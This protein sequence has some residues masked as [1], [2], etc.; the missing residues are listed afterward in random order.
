M[1][2]NRLKRSILPAAAGVGLAV[3]LAI[4]LFG[5]TG[6]TAGQT[7][8]GTSLGVDTASA[9]LLALNV[10][11]A[12]NSPAAANFDLVDQYGRR[13]SLAQFKGKVVVWSLNDDR[14]TDLCA[15]FA[16]DVASSEHDLG[17]AAKDVVFLSVNANPYYPSPSYVRQWSE[18]NHL[19]GFSNWVY[20]TGSPAQLKQ[21]WASYHV[22]VQLDPK[23]KTVVHEAIVEFID[24]QGR[25]RAIG[26]FDQGAISTAYYAHA[27]AEMADDLLPSAERVKVGG[28]DVDSSATSKAT[29]GS[30]AP[31]ISLDS[32]STGKTMTL[33]SLENRPTVLNFWASTCVVCTQEMPALEQVDRDFKGKV[34]FLGVDVAD[35]NGAARSFADHLGVRFPLVADRNGTAAADYEVDALP[36]T[37]IIAPG[38]EIVA[39]HDGA[40]THDELVAVLEMD[41]PNLPQI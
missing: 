14:C 36:V 25:T 5:S 32:L 11:P 3:V 37:F 19:E 29:I 22:T 9:Q 16:Q 10:M 15:L 34:D 39:R 38:G 4:V 40:L 6:Q 30:R 2:G 13:V 21:V 24:P 31:S 35:P 27:M 28:L 23:D 41:F 17:K 8:A 26:S 20:V 7:G 1:K 12:S 18:E 33:A